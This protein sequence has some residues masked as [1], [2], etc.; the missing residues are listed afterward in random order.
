MLLTRWCEVQFI[1]PFLLSLASSSS[2]SW[3]L[4]LDM[5][6]RYSA[7]STLSCCTVSW[8]MYIVHTYERFSIFCSPWQVCIS[9]IFFSLLATI[10]VIFFFCVFCHISVALF[11]PKDMLAILPHK[12]TASWNAKKIIKEWC[13]IANFFT[14]AERWNFE[15]FCKRISKVIISFALA[16]MQLCIFAPKILWYDNHPPFTVFKNHQKMSHS[17]TY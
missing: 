12:I 15:W 4:F 3:S 6:V 13:I 11:K 5:G 7:N 8:T 1:F 14:C 10:V 9:Q 16:L 2:R 17:S